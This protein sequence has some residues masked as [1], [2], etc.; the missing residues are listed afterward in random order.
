MSGPI[1][2]R[3]DFGDMKRVLEP[4]L[5]QMGLGKGV[6]LAAE[7]IAVLTAKEAPQWTGQK[8]KYGYTTK[9]LPGEFKKSIKAIPMGTSALVVGNMI[10]ADFVLN[11]RPKMTRSQMRWFRRNYPFGYVKQTPG[12]GQSPNDFPQ[13]VAMADITAI[14]LM[15]TSEIDN[16]I[17]G[18]L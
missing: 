15:V 5:Y 10:P 9:S 14:I 16:S 12:P 4:E 17:K 18:A 11:G 2:I 13:K 1:E 3:A 8:P 6:F 7:E